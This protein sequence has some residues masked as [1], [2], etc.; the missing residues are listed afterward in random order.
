M[1][2]LVKQLNSSKVTW[3]PVKFET[4]SNFEDQLPDPAPIA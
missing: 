1:F 3:T 2:Y 4:G